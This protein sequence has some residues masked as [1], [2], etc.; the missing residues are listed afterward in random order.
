[1]KDSFVAWT[2][3]SC[4]YPK[5]ATLKTGLIKDLS[6]QAWVKETLPFP[7][8]RLGVM[9]SWM[10]HFFNSIVAYKWLTCQSFLTHGPTYYPTKLVGSP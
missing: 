2:P 1:M 9:R 10:R 7:E 3:S 5:W 6:E 4:D 8:D